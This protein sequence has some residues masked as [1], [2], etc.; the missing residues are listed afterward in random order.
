MGQGYSGGDRVGFVD[1]TAPWHPQDTHAPPEPPECRGRSLHHPSAP[2][3]QQGAD[4]PGDHVAAP[5]T[6]CGGSCTGAPLG[7]RLSAVV[8]GQAHSCLCAFGSLALGGWSRA[9]VRVANGVGP[10]VW[11]WGAGARADVL[12]QSN[13]V[14]HA[15]REACTS[16][17]F[18]SD[19]TFPS[20][21][22]VSPMGSQ[23]RHPERTALAEAQRCRSRLHLGAARRG[24]FA[25]PP[26]APAISWVAA[27]SWVMG[28][29]ERRHVIL[30]LRP[31]LGR[32][33]QV[34]VGF[35]IL[36]WS[37]PKSWQFRR[38]VG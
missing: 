17:I 32:V 7:C 25:L 21:D 13:A 35:A 3:R 14:R 23:S 22:F 38:N 18:G 19:A 34:W 24:R 16:G 36:W 30:P 29:L 4:G 20:A 11:R 2:G 15:H 8:R 33:R 10:R 28:R 9:C 37:P 26:W 27:T 6:G 5:N 12:A 1:P 31:N